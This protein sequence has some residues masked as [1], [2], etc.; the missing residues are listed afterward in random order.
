MARKTVKFEYTPGHNYVRER[1][2]DPKS[3]TKGSYRTLSHSN[4]KTIPKG[5][6]IVTCCKKDAKRSPRG[7]C[8]TR[9]GCGSGTVQAIQ[10]EVGRFKKKHPDIWRKLQQAKPGKG[11]TRVVKGP[12]SRRR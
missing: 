4:V 12:G 11:G 6:N 3:C 9:R 10:H 8:C 7:K 5:V 1:L 2:L